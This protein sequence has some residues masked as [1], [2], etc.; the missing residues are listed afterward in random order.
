M[1][2]T[3]LDRTKLRDIT[4][5]DRYLCAMLDSRGGKVPRPVRG[6]RIAGASAVVG[7]PVMVDGAEVGALTS[8]GRSVEL[9]TIALAPLP[10]S[11]EVGAAVLVAGEP[12]TVTPL[13]MR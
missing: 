10:R 6:L 8:V 11:I 5:T 13:P 2:V 12:A 1:P 4:G 3:L 7:S 9:G